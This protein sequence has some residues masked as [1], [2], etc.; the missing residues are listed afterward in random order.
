[1]MHQVFHQPW[2]RCHWLGAG[3]WGSVVV[4]E[5]FPGRVELRRQASAAT[6]SVDLANK[7]LIIGSS[8]VQ[9]LLFHASVWLLS[10]TA[11]GRH[12]SHRI[13]AHIGTGSGEQEE[14]AHKISLPARDNN[15]ISYCRA[16][17]PAQNGR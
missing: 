6:G 14:R 9:C 8:V 10:S 5:A 15:S 2:R 3:S 7:D 1:V 17:V 11:P 12:S 16:F 13:S 4:R